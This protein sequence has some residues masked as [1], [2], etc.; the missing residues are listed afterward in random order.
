MEYVRG[1]REGLREAEGEF[2]NRLYRGGEERGGVGE[3]EGGVGDWCREE[4]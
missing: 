3:C 1:E 4:G 2:P